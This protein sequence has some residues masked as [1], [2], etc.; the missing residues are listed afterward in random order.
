MPTFKPAYL[1]HGDA[2]G[3]ITER[4]ARL[5][6]LAE[7][8]SG[9][10]G[11][12]TLEGDRASPEAVAGALMAMTFAVGRRFVIVD[13]AERWSDADVEAHLAPA[14]AA[15]A[16]DT[17]IAFF[18]R[19]D[20][21]AKAPAALAGA[22][23]R[24][25]GD[26]APEQTPRA[27]DLPRWLIGEATRLGVTLDAAGAQALVGRVGD[28]QQRALREL[29][30]LAI[31]HG[32]GA[33]IGVDEVQDAA[34]SSAELEVWGLVD[35]LVARDGAS[36]TRAFITLRAQGEALPR[37]VPSMVRRVRDILAIAVRLADG[38]S[39][40]QIKSSLRMSPYAADR[41]IKEA[42][43][44]DPD[45]LRH[46]LELLSD[47]EVDTRGGNELSDDTAA[48]LAI[49]AIATAA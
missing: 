29:E 23:T 9:V 31:E 6:A 36:A 20:G 38:E 26:V 18:A 2:H 13:G 47:L 22:V 15:I 46:A 27:R 34:S 25:G 40:A 16:P 48:L 5:R 43:G 14:L 10:G 3:R 39:P 21:R 24:A 1:I 12:E 30:K 17:T 37:L 41:R 4:R 35:A 42:R 45:R 28:R 44:A 19:E 11:V 33:R 7:S 8:E 32:A 49:D